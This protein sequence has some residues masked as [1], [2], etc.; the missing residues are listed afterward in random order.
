MSDVVITTQSLL[1]GK[2]VNET[3]NLYS[4]MVFL[5]MLYLLY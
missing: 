3:Y 2:L 5:Q 1:K 4:E